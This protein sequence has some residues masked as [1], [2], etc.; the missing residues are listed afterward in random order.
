MV[1]GLLERSLLQIAERVPALLA[2]VFLVV[3]F[4]R[5]QRHRDE[6]IREVSAECHKQ[7]AEA[8]KAMIENTEMLGRVAEVIRSCG[9]FPKGR[10]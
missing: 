5:Y 1:E 6:V 3:H 2:L 4:M 10:G 9:M 7:Q 8:T